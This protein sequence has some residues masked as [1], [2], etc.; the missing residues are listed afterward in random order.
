MNSRR[1]RVEHHNTYINIAPLVEV[2]LVLIIIFMITAPML[3][4]GIRVDLPKTKAATLDDSQSKPV[5]VSVDKSSNIYVD[6]TS[7]TVEGLKH[8]LPAMLRERKSNIVYVRGD[9]DLPYGEI[10]R[11][12]GA[13]S[14]LGVC[15]VSLVAEAATMNDDKTEKRAEHTSPSSPVT[16]SPQSQQPRQP[17]KAIKRSAKKDTKRG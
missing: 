15:K 16:T 1:R 8:E 9:K 5:I 12:M 7:T 14:S 17:R 2:M 13:I 4:V 11:I 6:D 10:M 3:N